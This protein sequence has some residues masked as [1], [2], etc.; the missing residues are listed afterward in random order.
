M[1]SP[2]PA[3]PDG[4]PIE[5]PPVAFPGAGSGA[6]AAGQGAAAADPGPSRLVAMLFPL[7][8]LVLGGALGALGTFT[9][10]DVVSLGP[11]PAVPVGIVLT[12]VLVLCGGLFSRALTG[13]WGIAGYTVGIF[14]A[15]ELMLREGPGGDL[16]VPEAPVSYVWLGG[17]VL[18]ALM[19][20]FLPARWFR[21]A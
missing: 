2:A 10:G 12:L 9:Y 21:R 1:T 20:A 5:V 17:A 3:T 15:S 18:L 8:C 16:M 4:E 7:A 6:G 13:W 11:W 14:A 19:V